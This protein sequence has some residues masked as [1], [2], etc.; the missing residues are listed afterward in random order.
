MTKRARK[1]PQGGSSA[2]CPTCHRRIKPKAEEAA[3]DTSER[4]TSSQQG[5]PSAASAP[6]KEESVDRCSDCG[7][8]FK[9]PLKIAG[10]RVGL[11]R[12]PLDKSPEPSHAPPKLFPRIFGYHPDPSEAPAKSVPKPKPVPAKPKKEPAPSAEF[13]PP[14]AD[15]TEKRSPSAAPTRPD[16]P[17]PK[18]PSEDQENKD[19]S[20]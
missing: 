13:S 4:A 2:K 18:P 8:A 3:T 7:R 12:K 19:V 14:P 11:D 5:K 10:V 15:P 17:K 20:K 16:T 9:R 6:K 1:S